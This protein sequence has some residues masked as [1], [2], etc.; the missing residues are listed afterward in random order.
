M[1]TAFD[2]GATHLALRPTPKCSFRFPVLE[3]VFKDPQTLLMFP[4]PN[5]VDLADF[6]KRSQCS[7]GDNGAGEFCDT[8]VPYNLVLL[9]GTWPQAKGIYCQNASLHSLTQ[10]RCFINRA[11]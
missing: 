4:G 8:G 2:H 9:D 3:E 7:G 5:A 1:F 10:V 11:S 6:V